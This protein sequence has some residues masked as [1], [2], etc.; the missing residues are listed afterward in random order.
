MNVRLN[1]GPVPPEEEDV[2]LADWRADPLEL[3]N[4]ATNAVHGDVYREL[5]TRLLQH[6]ADGIEPSMVPV[7]SPDQAPDFA[8][9]KFT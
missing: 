3:C 4:L 8:P 2:F 7:Y 5:R 6:C 1:G 9:P